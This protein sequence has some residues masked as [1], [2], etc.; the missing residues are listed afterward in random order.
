MAV[1]PDPDAGLRETSLDGSLVFEGRFLQLRRERVRLP[2]G[3]EATREYIL[4]PGAVMVVPI[5][6]DGRLLVERQWRHPLRRAFLEFPAG[7]LDPGEAPGDCARR[8]L[9]EETGFRAREWARAGVMHNAIAYSD[10]RI[11]VWFARGLQAGPQRLDAGEFLELESH[12][13][14]ALEAWAAEG[15]IT[16]AK[17]LVGLLWLRHARDGRWALAWQASGGE[18]SGQ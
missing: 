16:D 14:E 11:E 7:K 2:D 5:L 9:A 12:P 10:E 1:A 4:H 18:G 13:L 15:R 3:G 8:E 6:D 17:T